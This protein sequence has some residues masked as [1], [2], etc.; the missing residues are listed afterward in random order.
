M[1]L[2]G[3]NTEDCFDYENA[4]YLTS[5]ITRLGK[6]IV[7]YELYKMTKELPGH[8]LEFGVFKGSSLIK[9]ATFRE[10]FESPHSRKIVG[11]DIFGKFPETNFEKDKVAL[12]KFIKSAGEMSISIEELKKVLNYKKIQNFELVKGD[13]LET[14][15]E[16]VERNPQLKISLLHIDTDIYEPSKIILENLYDKV[17]RGGVI[18]LDDYGTFPGE[19]K[20]V[21]DFFAD[22][23][24]KIRKF[25]FSQATPSYILKD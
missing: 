25:P 13:I 2:L 16:Y 12:K 14:V 24:V 8:I 15:P 19:T 5:D 7:H 22:K 9:W 6:I 10:N 21:D 17:V 11:F 23:E 20:A 4:F 1:E 3:Y 18:I